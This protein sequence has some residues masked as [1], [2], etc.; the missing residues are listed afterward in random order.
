[1]NF[2]YNNKKIK[3]KHKSP[4][5]HGQLLAPITMQ[6]AVPIPSPKQEGK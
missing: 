5:G 1:M 6:F 4:K 2:N 3:N